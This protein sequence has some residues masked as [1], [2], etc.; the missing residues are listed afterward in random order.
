MIPSIIYEIKQYVRFTEKGPQRIDDLSCGDEPNV[1]PNVSHNYIMQIP[2]QSGQ[3][4]QHQ[5]EATTLEE[6]FVK[7][8]DEFVKLNN[9]VN[10][11]IVLPGV[12]GGNN[13]PINKKRLS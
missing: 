3:T 13:V 8:H 1:E 10:S 12:N 7:F 11:K 6:A 5:I 9:K 2:V 4:I